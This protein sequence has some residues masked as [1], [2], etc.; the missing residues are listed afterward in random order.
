MQTRQTERFASHLTVID[1]AG[2]VAIVVFRCDCCCCYYYTVAVIVAVAVVVDAAVV[3]QGARVGS[4]RAV[5][6]WSCSS[7]SG[8]GMTT[9]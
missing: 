7:W 1:A 9:R 5:L 8:S 3:V 6:R 2:T 4:G